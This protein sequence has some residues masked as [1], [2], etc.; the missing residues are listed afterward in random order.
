MD[1]GIGIIGTGG[2]ARA[3]AGAY[4]DMAPEVELLAVCEHSCCQTCCACF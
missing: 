2:I 1:I 3:H 4:L